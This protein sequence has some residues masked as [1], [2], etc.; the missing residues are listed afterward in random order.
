MYH[1]DIQFADWNADG[2]S[3]ILQLRSV[4]V[5]NCAGAFVELATR[6]TAA[7]GDTLYT[8]LPADWNGDGRADLLYIDAA[9]RQWFVVRSTGRGTR[10]CAC[11]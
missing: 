11:C 6:A 4:F 10:I 3:D 2:C 5:S 9:T 8:A 7:T 1:S